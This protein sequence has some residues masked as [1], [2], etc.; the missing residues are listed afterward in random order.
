MAENLAAA[1]GLMKLNQATRN[2]DYRELAEATI[3]GF[4]ETY[5]E[6]G[7]FAASYGLAVDLWL[8]P[9]VEITIEGPL[10]AQTRWPC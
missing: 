3:S 10:K 9:P 5:R 8:N 7:E 4:A 1:M 6:H 2:S